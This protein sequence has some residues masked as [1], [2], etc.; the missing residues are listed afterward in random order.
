MKNA[1]FAALILIFLFFEEKPNNSFSS[2]IHFFEKEK[3][4]VT[5]ITSK[6]H[7]FKPKSR[8]YKFKE[9]RYFEIVPPEYKNRTITNKTY[10]SSDY[11]LLILYTPVTE[12]ILVALGGWKWVEEKTIL[13]KCPDNIQILPKKSKVLKYIK[14]KDEY[15]TITKLVVQNTHGASR[16][17]NDNPEEYRRRMKIAQD[18][19]KNNNKKEVIEINECIKD[20]YLKEISFKDFVEKKSSDS[21]I[22]KFK[23]GSWT[24]L[25]PQLLAS[26]CE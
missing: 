19:I 16:L 18:M 7:F 9:D 8:K 12:Q 1:H 22:I 21:K 23:K 10:D 2:D 13:K 15:A 3:K 5:L 6:T 20:G 24:L 14:E 25:Q 4:T 11:K 26:D 17:L